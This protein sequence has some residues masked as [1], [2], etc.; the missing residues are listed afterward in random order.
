MV[1][2]T[3]TL[4][5]RIQGQQT[6]PL[7]WL[8]VRVGCLVCLLCVLSGCGYMVGGPYDPEIRS[9]HVPI[10]TSDL[11]R[12]D[13]HLELTEAV[14]KEIQS[15]TPFRLSSA[16]NADTRLTGRLIEIRKDVLGETS[17]D[18]ARQLQLSFAVEILWEDT[19]GGQLISKSSVPLDRK[20]HQLLSQSNFAPEI[21][22]SYATAKH[23][24]ITQL[25]RRIV[26]KM[27]T[28]W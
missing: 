28:P 17:F 10:F 13:V 18:D 11:F 14:Q 4:N 1:E 26:D 16:E 3:F 22:Q 12:R 2:N 21:G 9:V 19:Q 25:A 8:T 23:E 6:K 15:R 5:N 24:A 20:T 7:L 27:E